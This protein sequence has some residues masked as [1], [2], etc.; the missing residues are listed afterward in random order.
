MPTDPTPTW[1]GVSCPPPFERPHAL[2]L[3]EIF[4]LDPWVEVLP[5]FSFEVAA[6]A[7]RPSGR[8]GTAIFYCSLTVTLNPIVSP[9]HSRA[10][11]ACYFLLPTT[12]SLPAITLWPPSIFPPP[13]PPGLP[14]DPTITTIVNTFGRSGNR[15]YNRQC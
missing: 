4:T 2:A 5:K 11:V 9:E 15:H 13:L 8:G 12:R 10:D 14:P 6:S 7:L 1:H 3:Q